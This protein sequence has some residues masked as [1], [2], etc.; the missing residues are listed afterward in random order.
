MNKNKSAA[1]F[2]PIII[3]VLLVSAIGIGVYLF[4]SGQIRIPA[5]IPSLL[6]SSTPDPTADWK[7][8]KNDTYNFQIKYPEKFVL[9]E[10][11]KNEEFYDNLA[12]LSYL[13]THI[14]ID[15]ISNI[16]IYENE[17]PENVATREVMDGEFSY[18]ITPSEI[19][20][21]Q[22]AITILENSSKKYTIAH[23]T[24]NFFIVISLNTDNAEFNQILST[25]KFTR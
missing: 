8:Y 19:S 9:S 5:S 24:R 18:K 6:S 2:A 14:N 1:G 16:D 11:N 22:G 3:L 4:K 25:F 23:P 21:Y 12:S 13:N 17:K 15:A 20:G 7:A 10:N